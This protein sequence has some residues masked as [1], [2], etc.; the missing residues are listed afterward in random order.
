MRRLA[1]QNHVAFPVTIYYAF[2]QSE[3]R[4]DAGTVS[5][6]WETFLDAVICSGFC[7][8]RHMAAAYRT[9]ERG[10]IGNE[11]QRSRIQHRPCLPPTRCECALLR[12]GA[13]SRRHSGLSSQAAMTYL[14]RSNI[15]PVDLAQASIGPGMA[16]FTRYREVLNADGSTM[17]V[18]DALALI[19]ATLDEMLAE[20]EGDFDSDSRWALTWFEQHGYTDGEYGVAEQLSKSKNTS[21]DGLGRA[22]IVES[23]RGSVRLFKPDELDPDWDPAADRQAHRLG[24]D[25]PLDPGAGIRLASQKPRSWRPR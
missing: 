16:V 9:T 2:K 14:Q 17:S 4:G 23:R 5:S 20:Q 6:G 22:G 25:A 13:S 10:G 18:R 7:D 8:Q 21:V 19:N 11:R 1:D 3:T 12:R 24:D 15:A